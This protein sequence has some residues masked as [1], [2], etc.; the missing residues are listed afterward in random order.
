[1]K[2]IRYFDLSV[3]TLLIG[4]TLIGIVNDALNGGG[5]GRIEG[6]LAL[7]GMFIGPWQMLGA[8]IMIFRPGPFGG[9]RLVHLI[10]S[11][12]YLSVI[13][14]FGAPRSLSNGIWIVL[15]YL[16]PSALAILYYTISLRSLLQKTPELQPG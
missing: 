11:I 3:Q 14:V 1:M 7:G 5:I 6:T 2:A 4:A 10:S 8:F 16:I 13:I 15:T 12:I 9:W